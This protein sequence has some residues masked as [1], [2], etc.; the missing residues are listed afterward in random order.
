MGTS[1]V[2]VLRVGIGSVPTQASMYF[3]PE[4]QQYVPE[5][6]GVD[7][8]TT[9]IV[10][11]QNPLAN[12]TE[13]EL[14]AKVA[15]GTEPLQYLNG[16]ELERLRDLD[17]GPS[18][19]NLVASEMV[20]RGSEPMP[21]DSTEASSSTGD[22]DPSLAN[23]DMTAKEAFRSDFRNEFRDASIDGRRDERRNNRR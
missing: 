6:P 8:T 18:T 23:S 17:L 10:S 2:D 9:N 14:G 7:Q 3:D 19:N 5:T 13:I 22:I 15:S 12:D 20:A 21:P 1:E 16:T 11:G 4:L